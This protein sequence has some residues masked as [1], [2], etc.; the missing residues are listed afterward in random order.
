MLVGVF[1]VSWSS[2]QYMHHY[3]T[4][5]DVHKGAR[6]LRTF[7]WLD[8]LWL[9]HNWHQRHHEQPQVPWIYLPLLESGPVAPRESMWRA[10]RNQWHGPKLADRQITNPHAGQRIR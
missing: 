3:D 7:R 4:P 10:W 5:R 6:N 1:G 2:M 9:N 8:A